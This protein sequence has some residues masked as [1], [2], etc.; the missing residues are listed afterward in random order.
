MKYKIV[1]E[2]PNDIIFEKGCP[3]TSLYQPTHRYS[4]ENKQDPILFKN[5]IREIEN[6]LKEKFQRNDL[7]SIMEPFYQIEGDKEF[8]INTLD[9][10][11]IF[12]NPD[13]CIVYRLY[14][15]VRELAVVADSFHIKP[16]IRIFQSV[17]KYHLL[18]LS[19]DGF[20]LYEGNRFKIEKIKPDPGTHRTIEEVLGKHHTDSYLTYGS[21]GDADGRAMYHGHGGRKDEIE[22]D[23]ERF[24]RYVDRFV[25]DNYSKPTKLP[26]ILVSLKEYHNI[27]K[28]ISHNPYLMEEAIKGS[29]DAFE[30]EQL[31]EKVWQIIEPIYLEKIQDLVNSF[32]NAKANSLGSDNLDQ[33]TMAV[34]ENR[35][36]T[37]MIEDERIIPGKIDKNTGKI[38][39][40]NIKDPDFDDVLDDLAEMVLKKRGEAAVLPKEEMPSSTGVAAIYRYR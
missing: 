3:C 23:I 24:F 10:L 19:H 36:G 29:Y 15:P 2:F 40:G 26:L 17:D 12:A 9:G 33:I 39:L 27:F 20:T 35:V 18:G 22:K 6:S 28:K 31:K 8:W 32:E 30:A 37:I 38:E 1:K 7:N 4:P 16:L 13:K 25:L 5:L 14:M 21:Y 34:I 11:A